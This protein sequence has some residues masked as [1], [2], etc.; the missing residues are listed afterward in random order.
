MGILGLPGIATQQVTI[1]RKNAGSRV[2]GRWVD[3]ADLPPLV[4]VASLQPVSGQD[5]MHLPEG[6]RTKTVIKLYTNTV[7]Y[8]VREAVSKVADIIV[9][10][11]KEYEVSRVWPYRIGKRFGYNKVLAVDIVDGV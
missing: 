11:G 8:T 9:W 4:I 2:N 5:L 7:L 10:E 1:Q 6:Q 3:G